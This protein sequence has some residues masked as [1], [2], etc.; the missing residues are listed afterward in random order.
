MR[1]V[2]ARQTGEVAEKL[3][4]LADE[5]ERVARQLQNGETPSIHERAAN[6]ALTGGMEAERTRIRLRLSRLRAIEPAS[7]T[8]VRLR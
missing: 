2:A 5:F 3:R 6:Q 7:M 4:D 1:R 8:N